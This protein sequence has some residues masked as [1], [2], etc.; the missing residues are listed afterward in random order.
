[1]KMIFMNDRRRAALVRVINNAINEKCKKTGEPCSE[2]EKQIM[3]NIFEAQALEN[4]FADYEL[5]FISAE[6]FPNQIK[7]A[8]EYHRKYRGNNPTGIVYERKSFKEAYKDTDPKF[9]ADYFGEHQ[10]EGETV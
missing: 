9:V 1:M 5:G 7:N 10:S 8:I 6:D 2:V 3:D 4:V